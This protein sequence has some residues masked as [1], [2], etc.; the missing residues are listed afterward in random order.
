MVTGSLAAVRHAPVASPRLA[1]VY[2]DDPEA[3]A[4]ALAL[5]PADS[6]S[7]VTLV[8][9]LDPVV[10]ARSWVDEG[11]RYAA[12]SQ[13]AADL[14]TSPGR[15]PSEGEELIAWMKKNTD[16]WRA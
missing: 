16:A 15:G 9:P 6:G 8:R 7:N 3:A 11:I 2:V 14:L 4:K 10:F 5:R 12:L 13:V 1:A